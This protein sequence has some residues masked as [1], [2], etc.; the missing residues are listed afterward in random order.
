MAVARIEPVYVRRY[1]P[2]ALRGAPVE[3][4]VRVPRRAAMVGFILVGGMLQHVMATAPSEPQPAPLALAE[5]K[6]APV[7]A[8]RTAPVPS[9]PTHHPAH[10]SHP[11]PRAVL[12][13]HMIKVE[14][15][16]YVAHVAPRV[17]SAKHVAAV[18]PPALRT[19]P[20]LPP[21]GAAG[22][23]RRVAM[24]A[25]PQG[26]IQHVPSVSV[27]AIRAALRVAGS[28]ALAGTYADHKDAGEYIWDSGRV[29]GID[30]AVVMAIFRYESMFGTRGIAQMTDS[31]GN[32]RP[33]AGQASLGGYRLYH[34]WE[35]GID[36]CYRLLRQYARAGATTIPLAIPA[37]APA[38][39]NN[40]PS[41]YVENVLG[42]MNTLH[43][44]SAGGQP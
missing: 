2:A 26:I 14:H 25:N 29:L 33:L 11:V 41:A 19:S 13:L 32:I 35:E 34:S 4:R 8:V 28:P 7:S 22:D 17:I 20:L 23:A 42:I 39:D 44:A 27:G 15:T 38:S 36:D 16:S 9:V 18:R 21:V 10:L 24:A 3:R 30:P 37:W 6:A 40:D 43:A 5:P 12:A 1:D 31:V